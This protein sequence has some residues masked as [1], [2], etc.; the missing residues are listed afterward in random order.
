MSP[1]TTEQLCVHCLRQGWVAQHS[2]LGLYGERQ[3][4]CVC[5]SCC[6]QYGVLSCGCCLPSVLP[7][8]AAAASLPTSGVA[9]R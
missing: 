9:F 2:H 7:S 1:C 4:R 6:V 8:L 5:V 3:A